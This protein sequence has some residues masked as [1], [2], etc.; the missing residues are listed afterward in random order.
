MTYCCYSTVG[1]NYGVFLC[2]DSHIISFE[3]YCK[4]LGHE[5]EHMLDYTSLPNQLSLAFSIDMH[6]VI[7]EK[8]LE[9]DFHKNLNKHWSPN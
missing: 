4:V 6:D 8:E 5:Q 3:S 1:L 2:Y 7:K 9:V